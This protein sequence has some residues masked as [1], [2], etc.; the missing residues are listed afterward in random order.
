M[1]HQC[2][3]ITWRDIFLISLEKTALFNC[4]V[5]RWSLVPV[6]SCSYDSVLSGLKVQR[7]FI[8]CIWNH[9]TGSSISLYNSCRICGVF[10]EVL[11][12]QTAVGAVLF[13]S[14]MDFCWLPKYNSEVVWLYHDCAG[15]VTLKDS[16]THW[17][18]PYISSLVFKK[19]V[20]P[21]RVVDS[22]RWKW[23]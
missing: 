8:Y 21:M 11:M 22:F 17:Q 16:I 18:F 7:H 1:L 3:I 4:H 19:K 5:S 20:F 9:I 10:K 12:D 14:A 6:Y 23:K 15:S 2:L 13:R